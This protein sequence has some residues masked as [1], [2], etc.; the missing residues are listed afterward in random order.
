MPVEGAFIWSL[1]ASITYVTGIQESPKYDMMS[2]AAPLPGALLTVPSWNQPSAASG[3]GTDICPIRPCT[4][5]P[6]KIKSP[7]RPSV[8]LMKVRLLLTDDVG[9]L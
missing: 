9:E 8:L 5:V 1:Y 6:L 2:L 3:E 4:I 7:L